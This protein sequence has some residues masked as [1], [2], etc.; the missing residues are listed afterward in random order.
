MGILMIIGNSLYKQRSKPT[1][2]QL[3]DLLPRIVYCRRPIRNP[4]VTFHKIPGHEQDLTVF[5]TASALLKL[6]ALPPPSFFSIQAAKG[7]FMSPRGKE[8]LITPSPTLN[9][10][11]RKEALEDM[12]VIIIC[13]VLL[14]IDLFQ[15]SSLSVDVHL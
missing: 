10:R 7:S 3:T 2:P 9:N 4:R 6:R 11:L 12:N 1:Q 13:G 8:P 5:S 14:V 15:M